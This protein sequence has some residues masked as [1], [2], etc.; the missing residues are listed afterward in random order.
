MTT[1]TKWQRNDNG[2]VRSHCGDWQITNDSQGNAREYNLS[3]FGDN[4]NIE[5]LVP[6]KYYGATFEKQSDAKLYV[7]EVD[8]VL[9]N[10]NNVTDY[11]CDL[12]R[13]WVARQGVA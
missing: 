4:P 10:N 12:K 7:K 13:R 6:G 9:C 3:Y 5:K 2:V 8:T 1:M 11:Y